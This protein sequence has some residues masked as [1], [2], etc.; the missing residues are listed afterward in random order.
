[1]VNIMSDEIKPNKPHWRHKYQCEICMSTFVCPEIA[2]DPEFDHMDQRCP[3][4]H[5]F[6]LFKKFNYEKY[7]AKKLKYE[8]SKKSKKKRNSK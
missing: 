5:T 3:I 4:C 2:Y 6:D 8:K 7:K 1:M